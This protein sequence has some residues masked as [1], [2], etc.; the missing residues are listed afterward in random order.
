MP[1]S[2]PSGPSTIPQPQAS[3]LTTPQPSQAQSTSQY[4]LSDIEQLM[5]MGFSREEAIG[6]LDLAGGNLEMAAGI[7][8]G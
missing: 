3:A 2:E 8:Y 6:A 1:T 5:S 7:L 4:S